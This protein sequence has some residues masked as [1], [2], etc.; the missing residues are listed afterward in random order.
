M[1]SNPSR[2]YGLLDGFL[3]GYDRLPD[4]VPPGDVAPP[5]A[6]PDLPVAT[7]CL[8]HDLTIQRFNVFILESVP[9]AL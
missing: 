6:E 3:C 4:E 8:G 9:H 5:V 1:K 2:P 7:R